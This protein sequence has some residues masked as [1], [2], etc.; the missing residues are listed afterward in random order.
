MTIYKFLESYNDL[1][2]DEKIEELLLFLMSSMIMIRRYDFFMMIT[3]EFTDKDSDMFEVGENKL[4]VSDIF[5]GNIWRLKAVSL[6]YEQQDKM[7]QNSCKNQQEIIKAL[8]NAARMFKGKNKEQYCN[9]GLGL[10]FNMLGRVYSQ[11]E[12]E[13]LDL[14]KS[15]MYFFKS[16]ECFGKIDHPRG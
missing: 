15:L 4:P 16:L 11:F 13:T 14:E 8:E 12:G 9:W 7:N 1:L 6:F 5:L 2:S 10:T 3:N